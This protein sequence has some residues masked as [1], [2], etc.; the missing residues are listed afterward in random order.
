[1][2][3]FSRI[4]MYRQVL[5]EVRRSSIWLTPGVFFIL[6]GLA[7][8][9][10]PEFVIAVV[11]GFCLFV[12]AMLCFLGWKLV[13]FKSRVDR[14]LQQFDGRIFIQGVS[15]QPQGSQEEPEDQKKIIL[16]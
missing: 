10:A 7:A 11:A 2:G 13:Q 3:I 8:L 12:G 15:V 4:Q 9:L 1:M 6:L 14:V 16:H 5:P